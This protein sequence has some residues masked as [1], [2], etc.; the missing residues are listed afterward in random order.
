MGRGVS[1]F[2]EPKQERCSKSR[3]AEKN[4]R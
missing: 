3:K 4:N 2:Y 1:E